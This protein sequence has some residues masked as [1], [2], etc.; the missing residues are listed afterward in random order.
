MSAGLI[1]TYR[2]SGWSS[3]RPKWPRCIKLR[4]RSSSTPPT[5]PVL[6]SKGSPRNKP[7]ATVMLFSVGLLYL[8]EKWIPMS[9]SKRRRLE[10]LHPSEGKESSADHVTSSSCTRDSNRHSSFSDLKRW[11]PVSSY[12]FLFV[13]NK[14]VTNIR[15]YS[16]KLE[17]SYFAKRY[18]T[19]NIDV[20]LFWYCLFVCQN[21]LY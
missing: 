5:A 6:L 13:D 18:F 3:R 9:P 12:R 2:R 19:K 4:A 14:L 1:S 20:R 7:K 17:F 10:I 16:L 15:K 8:E 21:R 11:S